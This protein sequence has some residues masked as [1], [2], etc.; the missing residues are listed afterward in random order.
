MRTIHTLIAIALLAPVAGCLAPE[1]GV[2]DTRIRGTVVVPA[3]SYA[4]DRERLNGEVD[5]AEELPTIAYGNTVLTGVV[6]AWGWD[7]EAGEVTEDADQDWYVV[8]TDYSGGTLT[9]TIS[10]DDPDASYQILLR[11]LDVIDGAGQAAA[12]L[13]FAGGIYTGD[14]FPL[15]LVIDENTDTDDLEPDDGETTFNG[16]EKGVR[17]GLHVAG[18]DGSGE[19]GYTA[20][21]AGQHPDDAGVKAGAFMP[22]EGGGAPDITDKGNPVAGGTVTGFELQEDHSYVGAY[23]MYLVREV[24]KTEVE[25]PEDT[26]DGMATEVLVDEALTEAYIYAVDAATLNALPAGTWFNSEPAQVD[27]TAT[28]ATDEEGLEY[29]TADAVTLDDFSPL[30]IGWEM[31]ETEPNDV[32]V[33]LSLNLDLSDPSLAQDIGLLSGPGFVDFLRGTSP[34]ETDEPGFLHDVDAFKFQVPTTQEIFF[35][36]D[37]DDDGADIDIAMV[38]GDGAFYDHGATAN[39]PETNAWGGAILEPEVDYFFVVLGYSAAAGSEV[40]YQL[41]LEQVAR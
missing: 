37:W 14:A 8:T 29:L 7:E 38:D 27:L 31:D 32:P 9:L 6:N 39:K 33:D 15:Q 5:N 36:L 22:A 1:E 26:A 28:P 18:V 13:I 11:N 24:I 34:F 20:V 19:A 23:E 30:V 4:E 41:M 10:V 16:V 12:P 3:V 25:D 2:D 17:Y 40:S 35:T 21:I